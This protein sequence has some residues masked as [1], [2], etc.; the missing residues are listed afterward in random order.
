[1]ADEL[2]LTDNPAAEDSE[3][4]APTS[5]SE[6]LG[7]NESDAGGTKSTGRTSPSTSSPASPRFLD[8]D[9]VETIRDTAHVPARAAAMVGGKGWAVL[10][11]GVDIAREAR[12][13]EIDE[14]QLMKL[15]AADDHRPL[16]II[17]PR[18][19]FW[20]VWCLV[21]GGII[22]L[23]MFW[24]PFELAFVCM[25]VLTECQGIS[26]FL[27][28]R[29]VEDD[30]SG[31]NFG[32][33]V[34]KGPSTLELS[35][36]NLMDVLI[37]TD[38]GLHFVLGY[39]KWDLRHRRPIWIWHEKAIVKHYV[40][41][42][43]FFYDLVGCLPIDTFYRIQGASTGADG[44]VTADILSILR[45]A[46]LSSVFKL[47]QP[48]H[49]FVNHFAVLFPPIE[50]ISKLFMLILWIA[51]ITHIMACLLYFVGHPWW[52]V[53]DL[54]C[55]DYGICGWVTAQDW[56]AEVFNPGV[57]YTGK[58]AATVYTKYVTALYYAS[59]QVRCGDAATLLWRH[60]YVLHTI[61]TEPVAV[62]QLRSPRLVSVTSA[63]RRP[64]KGCFLSSLKCKVHTFRPEIQV[65]DDQAW[66]HLC[67]T[68]GLVA[69]CSATFWATF[70]QCLQTRTGQRPHTSRTWRRCTTL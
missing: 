58:G 14:E 35:V 50:P 48:L 6:V 15:H 22:C 4:V 9:T 43:S 5:D 56:E 13:Q 44:Y 10:R 2:E 68:T 64:L 60:Y 1:M 47:T 46:R 23:L 11:A 29:T 27:G 18:S 67:C 39:S 51:G 30:G 20:Q 21:Q 37:L 28:D 24:V 8:R 16:W 53:G 61:P 59:T 55:L 36:R 66:M 70:L 31:G 40:A 57:G 7:G 38:F 45:I 12:P 26:T 32:C 63:L 3:V 42:P 41:S 33:A 54:R 49:D 65:L 25:D 34:W 19:T 62:E 17:D 69:S 52:D